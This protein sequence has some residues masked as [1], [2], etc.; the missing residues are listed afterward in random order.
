VVAVVDI[1]D[2]N[3]VAK[4]IVG[5]VIYLSSSDSD[6]MTGQVLLVDRGT[7]FH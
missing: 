5:T 6:M 2:P 7:A 1:L 3:P 4:E